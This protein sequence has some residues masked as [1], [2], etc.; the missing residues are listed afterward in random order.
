MTVISIIVSPSF[1]S[2]PDK[3]KLKSNF[4]VTWT[5]PLFEINFYLLDHCIFTVLFY[6]C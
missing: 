1:L 3:M 2:C 6:D 5:V 4:N